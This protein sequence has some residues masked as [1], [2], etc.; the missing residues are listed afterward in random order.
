MFTS[1]TP[2]DTLRLLLVEDDPADI[3]LFEDALKTCPFAVKLEVVREGDEAIQGL[4]QQCDLGRA[5]P[6]LIVLDL[7]LP[8]VSGH[9]VLRDLKHDSQLRAIPVIVFTS[10]SD[11]LDIVKAYD[12]YA[13]SFVLKPNDLDR[14]VTVVCEMLAFWFQAVE[15]PR[16]SL[17]R[18]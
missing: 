4:Q 12:C 13:N 8:G 18:R 11:S 17:Y 6:N 9:Q 10:C 2:F 16:S 5:M 15:L 14:F 3:A 1:S 7:T